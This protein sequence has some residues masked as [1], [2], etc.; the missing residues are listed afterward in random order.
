MRRNGNC[1]TA[2]EF[3]QWYGD[4]LG[5]D[6]WEEADPREGHE[7]DTTNVHS[8]LGRALWPRETPKM[9]MVVNGDI[10]LA[11]ATCPPDGMVMVRDLSQ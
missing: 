8:V 3:V 10:L 5:H 7:W 1:Y 11:A 4:E 6:R 9:M 2:E